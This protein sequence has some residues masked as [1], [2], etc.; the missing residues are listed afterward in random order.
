[1]NNDYEPVMKKLIKTVVRMFYDPQHAVIADIL[2]ESVLLSDSE[3]CAKMKMLSREFNK[4]IIKLK[5]DHLIKYDIKVEV[6]EDN[7]QLLRTVYFFNHAEVKDIIKYKIF[8]MTKILEEKMRVTEENFYC[9]T[10]DRTFSALDAQASMDGFVFKCIFCKNELQEHAAKVDQSEIDL[11]ELM[12]SLSQVIDLLKVADSFKI[13]TLDYFQVL[14]MKK[15]KEKTETTQALQGQTKASAVV[16][17][18]ETPDAGNGEGEDDEFEDVA[19]PGEHTNTE[20]GSIDEFVLVNGAKRKF[21][22]VT[23]EDKEAM[24][25]NEYT[26]YFEVYSKHNR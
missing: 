16:E 22:E 13:P 8:R 2:L 3:F 15:E 25:E 19:E 17:L 11:K 20:A 24:D 6:Q 7:K 18:F 5:E 1:M 12:N 10:C 26:K 21:S 14:E 4:L 23:E 9:S